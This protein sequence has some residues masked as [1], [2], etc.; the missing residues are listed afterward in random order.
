M[1]LIIFPIALVFCALAAIVIRFVG[2]P[3]GYRIFYAILAA[4]LIA[5]GFA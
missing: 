1:E 3:I 4:V 2:I 5:K